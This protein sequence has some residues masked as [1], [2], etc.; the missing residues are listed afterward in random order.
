M[1]AFSTKKGL[2]FVAAAAAVALT[3]NVALP[4]QAAAPL[5]IGAIVP[6]TGALAFLAAPEIAGI[7]LAVD[8]INAAGGVNGQKVQLQFTDSGDT[9]TP[10]IAPQSA[11]KLLAWG[12]DTIIGAAS[13]G[14]SKL[15]IDQIT[16]KKVVQI[17]P[18]N[19][20][21][22]FTTAKDGG[23]YF[24]TAP[25]DAIQGA[26]VA[27]QIVKDG[28]ANV[29]IIAQQSAYGTG[30]AARAAQ[31]LKKAGATV[32]STQYFPEQATDFTSIV[33]TT[34]AAKPDAILL[35]SYDE[36]KKAIPALQAKKFDGSKL[37]LV[38]GNL[39]DYSKEAFASYLKGAKGTLPGTAS[40]AAK[41]AFETRLKASYAAHNKGKS[42][43]ELS[44][45]AESYDA[46]ILAAL[47][48]TQGKANDGTT[49]S[50][51]LISVSKTGTKVTSFAAGVKAIKAGKDIDYN[52]FSGNIEFDAVGDPTAVTI[53]IYQYAADGTYKNNLLSSVDGTTV[54]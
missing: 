9:T 39:A 8:D 30:L 20:S 46:V 1:S 42:L 28:R 32:V 21:P 35:V 51:N 10:E 16:K 38:D 27:N 11:T 15:I 45:G 22:F 6:N 54:K 13:S 37:Y 31:V 18:A 23:Y 41:T 19:T 5:K 53:N 26:V 24:R 3:F 40:S 2:A 43:T 50:K 4:A 52:G 34:L 7:Q 49:I 36:A 44:Y 48:A 47:A 12:A 33:D 17:S 29:A 25:S 14:V